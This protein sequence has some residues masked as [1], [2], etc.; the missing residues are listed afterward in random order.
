MGKAD[1]H[2]IEDAGLRKGALR[3]ATGTPPGKNIS[4]KRLHAAAR[5]KNGTIRKEAKL[6]ETLKGL[7]AK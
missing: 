7:R 6:A 3:K 1:P 4:E 2:W 5:S